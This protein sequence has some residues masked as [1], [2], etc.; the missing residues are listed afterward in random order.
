MIPSIS[1]CGETLAENLRDK[2]RSGQS[3]DIR[4]WVYLQKCLQGK[5]EMLH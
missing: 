1:K 3:A 2:A 4:G 5:T